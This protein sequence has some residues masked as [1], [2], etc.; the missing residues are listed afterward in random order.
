MAP[1]MFWIGFLALGFVTNF[2]GKTSP[3]NVAANNERNG[4]PPALVGR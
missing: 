2:P 1:I 4:A 3:M